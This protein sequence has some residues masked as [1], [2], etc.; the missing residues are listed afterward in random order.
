MERL[1]RRLFNTVRFALTL[2]LILILRRNKR[3]DA[4]RFAVEYPRR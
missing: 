1:G 2:P 4:D 3:A